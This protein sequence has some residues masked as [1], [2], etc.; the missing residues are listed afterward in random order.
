MTFH[1]PMCLSVSMD[2]G[3]LQEDLVESSYIFVFI[4]SSCVGDFPYQ[5][6]RWVLGIQW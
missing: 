6:V 2:L 4:Q 3:L 1:G 5:A